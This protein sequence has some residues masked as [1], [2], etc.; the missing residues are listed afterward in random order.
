[1]TPRTLPAVVGVTFIASLAL[2]FA[3]PGDAAHR[4]SLEQ[5]T[6]RT[7]SRFDR[8]AITE[9]AAEWTRAANAWAF[10]H[11]STSRI[12][13]FVD[14][15]SRGSIRYI[16]IETSRTSHKGADICGWLAIRTQALPD[17]E[18]QITAGG[19]VTCSDLRAS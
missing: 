19:R 13:S 12:V 5:S 4:R 6:T 9:T 18:R 14:R 15:G 3:P 2:G 8:V 16:E 11:R 17:P 1:M 7:R 10:K